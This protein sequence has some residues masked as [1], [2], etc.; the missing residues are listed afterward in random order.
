MQ[1]FNVSFI[2]LILKTRD[3]TTIDKF[4]PI[5]LTNFKFKIITKILADKIA[6]VMPHLISKEKKGFIKGRNIHDWFVFLL[7][8]LIYLIKKPFEGMWLLKW[9]L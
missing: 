9:M 4:Q 7:K 5:A 8:T 6:S 3:G 2:V 1:N